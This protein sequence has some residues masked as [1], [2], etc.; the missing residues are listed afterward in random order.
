MQAG[1]TISCTEM[2]T[3]G[4]P[5]RI[6]ESGYPLIRGDTILEKRIYAR[7][8]LDDTRRLLMHEPR[9]HYDMYGAV[10]VEADLPQADFGV[11]FIH[12]EGLSS[13]LV[14]FSLMRE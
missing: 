3:G 2:H 8:Y 7:Q 1:D 9:G 14:N 6:V 10:L 13:F 4:E 11:L 12:N 5:L